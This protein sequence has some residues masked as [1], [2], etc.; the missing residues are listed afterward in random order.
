MQRRG[1]RL[2]PTANRRAPQRFRRTAESRWA[3]SRAVRP[4]THLSVGSGASQLILPLLVVGLS[5]APG[6]AALV[7]V[8]PR[9]AYVWK[10]GEG[11][12]AREPGAGPR[13]PNAPR[14]WPHAQ[15]SKVGSPIAQSGGYS[16]S[17]VS[18]RTCGPT[19]SRPDPGSHDGAAR[20]PDPCGPRSGP[21]GPS[22]SITLLAEARCPRPR[23]PR[24]RLGCE[25]GWRRIEL[26][27][28]PRPQH[29]ETLT[30]RSALARKRKRKASRFGL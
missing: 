17:K 2:V 5:L 24:S 1:D 12:S 9:D 26:V 23:R 27:P 18:S 11:A 30:H 8:V 16:I 13:Q 15:L 3:T 28:Q 25:A 7:P 19:P 29:R 20:G 14:Q 6:L 22:P 21:G 10:R 4:R